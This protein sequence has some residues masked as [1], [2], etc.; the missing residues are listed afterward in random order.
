MQLVLLAIIPLEGHV[1]DS[2]KY[3]FHQLWV[4]VQHGMLERHAL[5]V[6]EGDP[7]V[8]RHA[9]DAHE[10]LHLSVLVGQVVV[11][12]EHLLHDEEPVEVVG[13]GDGAARHEMVAL[14]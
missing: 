14:P 10:Q 7:L 9:G 5:G 8:E 2:R 3:V 12:A 1:V 11:V 13:S 4:C 6:G